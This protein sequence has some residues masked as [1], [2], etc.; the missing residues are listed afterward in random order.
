MKFFYVLAALFPLITAASAEP[1][2]CGVPAH[3]SPAVNKQ[4]Y[5]IAKS[6]G[7]DARELLA[8]F[9]TAWVESHMNNLPCGDRDSVGVF[10]QRPSAGWGTKAQCQDVNHATNTFIN[11]LIPIARRYPKASAGTLAQKVQGSAYPARYDQAQGI[12][13]QLIAQA[14]H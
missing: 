5:N 8:T 12:A 13:R 2:A 4:V 6:R 10:Q 14:Q 9:E 3:A 11:H 7:L 1:R